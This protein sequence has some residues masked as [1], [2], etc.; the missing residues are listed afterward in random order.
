MNGFAD[1]HTH[2]L[3]AVDDGAGSMAEALEMIQA[4]W[5]N[6][7]RTIFLTPHYR[8]KFKQN[9]PQQLREAFD[10]LSH[11]AGEKYPGLRL[12]LGNEACFETDAPERL[13]AGRI[14]TLQD[15]RY[16]L[17]EFSGRTPRSQILTGVSETVRYGYVPIIAHAERYDAFY[18]DPDLVY[19]V[20]DMGALIQL[21]AQSVMGKLGLKVKRFC[22]RLLKEQLVHFIASDAHDC[23]KRPPLLRDCFLRVHKKYGEQLACSIFYENAEAVIANKMI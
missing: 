2:I 21:N 8:A 19:E 14:L 13:K 9:T 10:A 18:S 20:L 23:A 15:S 11:A 5:E 17:L 7:T 4:A 12:C 22:H 3:P 1:I 16:V 6:G